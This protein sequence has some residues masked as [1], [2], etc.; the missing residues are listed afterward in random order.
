MLDKC[1]G[2]VISCRA[3]QREVMKEIHPEKFFKS[4]SVHQMI[5]LNDKMNNDREFEVRPNVKPGTEE[6]DWTHYLEI[7]SFSGPS[8]WI[9]IDAT[10]KDRDGRHMMHR[11]I[12]RIRV[13]E[14]EFEQEFYMSL[15]E[16]QNKENP[17]AML[18]N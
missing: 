18:F 4:L 2:V 5:Q 1:K 15:D 6:C 9:S 11:I 13:Y 7:E 14:N 8:L 3:I 12:N 17:I 16:Y 10:Y